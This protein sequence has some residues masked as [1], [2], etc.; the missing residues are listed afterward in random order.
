LHTPQRAG[1]AARYSGSP[2]PMHPGE[3]GRE[4]SVALVDFE[5]RTPR[6]RTLAVPVFQK[7]ERIAGDM[8]TIELRLG[9]LRMQGGSVW[10]EIVYEGKSLVPNLRERVA[11]QTAGSGVE[12]L[13]VKDS[14]VVEDT[15]GRWK[16]G[17]MLDELD[18]TDV[19]S[20]CLE[21]RSVPDADRPELLA[22]YREILASIRE[23]DPEA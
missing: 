18:E 3:A 10:A 12:I 15:L 14:R 20:R 1:G 7:M 9:E 13:C 5:G 4:K 16:A 8:E 17:E 19:F 2:L 11:A 21:K 22:A 6:V 23:D